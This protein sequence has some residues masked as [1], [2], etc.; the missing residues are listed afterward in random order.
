[1]K[2]VSIEDAE[3]V[4]FH[5][6]ELCAKLVKDVE[7]MRLALQKY[8]EGKEKVDVISEVKAASETPRAIAFREFLTE[9]VTNKPYQC[10][11][12]QEEE[13]IG[14]MLDDNNERC[15]YCEECDNEFVAKG[16]TLDEAIYNWNVHFNGL[17]P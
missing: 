6:G 1:M 11:R 16:K 12:C 15:V 14:Y 4:L 3:I 17:K 5:Y 9:I 7:A 2:Q 10:P 8:E 13:G